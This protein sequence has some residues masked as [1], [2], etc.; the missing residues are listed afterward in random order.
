MSI[1]SY[2]GGLIAAAKNKVK[3][4]LQSKIVADWRATAKT[5]S[6]IVFAAIVA[7]PEIFDA[8]QSLMTAVGGEGNNVIL[9]KPFTDFIRA[10]GVIGLV[11]RFLKQSKQ[12][13]LEAAKAAE[14]ERLAAEAAKPKPGDE[15]P[16]A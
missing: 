2:I 8:F 1:A 15:P 14:A 12:S 16:A 4:V 13:I 10:M 9:P 6:V 11:V 3:E 5:Y 7:S